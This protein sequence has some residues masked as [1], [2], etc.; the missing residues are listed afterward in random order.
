M[1]QVLQWQN[2]DNWI[3]DLF[4]RKQIILRADSGQDFDCKTTRW[5]LRRI[6]GLDCLVLNGDGFDNGNVVEL[7]TGVR[8][9]VLLLEGANVSYDVIARKSGDESISVLVFSRCAS[10]GWNEHKTI[11]RVGSTEVMVKNSR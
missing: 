1:F 2:I 8:P 10:V 6:Y 9:R 3:P 4:R 11:D 7:I 5:R